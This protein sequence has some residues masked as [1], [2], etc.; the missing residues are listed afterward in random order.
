MASSLEPWQTDGLEPDATRLLAL[1]RRRG[2]LRMDE[3]PAALPKGRAAG[4]L[5]RLLESR[6]LARGGS[7]HTEAGFH[8]KALESWDRWAEDAE[9]S[10]PWP[11]P[12]AARAVFA[13]VARRWEKAFGEGPRFPWDAPPPA[14]A[15]RRVAKTKVPA[16]ARKP[17][18]AKTKAPARKARK[19]RSRDERRPARRPSGVRRK[20]AR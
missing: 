1:V 12:A 11:T 19:A 3:L 9:A 15:K 17:A 16:R 4:D 20:R 13:A 5:A 18:R 2:T 14:R 6:L 10:P 7:V 8:V